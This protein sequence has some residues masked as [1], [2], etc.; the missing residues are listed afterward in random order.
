MFGMGMGEL[1]LILVVALLVVGPDKLPQAAKAIGKG[2]R[3][4]RK[5]TQDLQDTIEKDEKLGEAVRELKSAL[6]GTALRPPYRPPAPGSSPVPPPGPPVI[7]G[8]AGGP[9]ALAP[10][11]ELAARPPALASRPPAFASRPPAA[12]GDPDVPRVVP[13]SGAIAKGEDEPPSPDPAGD[14]P[15]HG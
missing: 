5:T 6:H 12:A 1:L 2:I 3:D 14:E 15:R 13:A 11:P 9:A 7:D 8:V 10:P 4:F